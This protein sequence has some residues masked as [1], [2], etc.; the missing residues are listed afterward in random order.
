MGKKN[1]KEKNEWIYA[2]KNLEIIKIKENLENLG[3]NNNFDEIKEFYKILDEYLN[4]NISLS[5]K[6]KI[7]Y[8]NKI[9]EYQLPKNKIHSPIVKLIQDK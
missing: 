5:G 7:E 8:I 9:I 3:L 2:D 1:K 4:N 6:I